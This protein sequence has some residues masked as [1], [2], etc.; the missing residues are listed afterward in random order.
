MA[1][2]RMDRVGWL[3]TGETEDMAYHSELC[4]FNNKNCVIVN[5]QYI[6]CICL[7]LCVL[8]V[9]LVINVGRIVCM[10]CAPIWFPVCVC[11]CVLIMTRN[12]GH[13]CTFCRIVLYITD[14]KTL[15]RDEDLSQW[16]VRSSTKHTLRT[17]ISE[18]N[19]ARLFRLVARKKRNWNGNV[20]K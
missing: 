20:R 2:K 13:V 18:R 19:F 4:V 15:L 9:H 3:T 10:Y 7:H 11:V 17:N 1:G 6:M 16:L 8:D 5:S 14:L 12:W